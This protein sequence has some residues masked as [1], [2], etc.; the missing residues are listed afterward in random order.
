MIL[1][2]VIFLIG[3]LFYL[4]FFLYNRCVISHDAYILAFRGSARCREENAEVEKYIDN[5]SK[6]QFGIKYIGL[7][8]PQKNIE[9]SKKKVTVIA[10]G[11]MKVSFINNFNLSNS[12]KLKSAAEA[13]RIC[14][15]DFI[16]KIRFLQKT[17]EDIK[18]INKE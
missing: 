5:D 4:S 16:R 9:V 14:P 11:N 17:G 8:G 2:L 18:N 15:V 1:P 3:F 13:E 6:R 7:N 12:W 10:E